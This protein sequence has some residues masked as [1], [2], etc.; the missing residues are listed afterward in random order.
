MERDL[1]I[2]DGVNGVNIEKLLAA[3]FDFGS[4]LSSS[5]IA[6]QTK[7]SGQVRQDKYEDV[8]DAI[9]D[10]RTH[11]AEI[12]RV[13]PLCYEILRLRYGLDK[14]I[15]RISHQLDV[16]IEDVQALIDLSLLYVNEVSD[17]IPD[18]SHKYTK[19][20]RSDLVP[21]ST[22]IILNGVLEGI[23]GDFIQFEGNLQDRVIIRYFVNNKEQIT[24]Q[25]VFDIDWY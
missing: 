3:A 22:L 5:S 8:L 2:T 4:H 16:S 12:R 11:L 15:H 1:L 24:I 17:Q 23:S 13:N 14:E 7:G 6:N 21:G 18:L 9:L 10:I 20:I 25:N 19:P